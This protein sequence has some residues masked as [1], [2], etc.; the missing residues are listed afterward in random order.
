[1]LANSRGF[2]QSKFKPDSVRTDAG[3][4]KAGFGDE[5]PLLVF[6]I[7]TSHRVREDSACD[8]RV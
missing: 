4:L 1:M 6:G 3:A 7:S 5:I 8:K 2:M